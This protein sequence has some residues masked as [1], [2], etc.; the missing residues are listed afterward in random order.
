ASGT[1]LGSDGVRGLIA[2]HATAAPDTRLRALLSDLKR[3]KLVD[4]TTLLLIEEP[5]AHD[6]Q[7]LL[8][9]HMPARAENLREMRNALRKT[10]DHLGVEPALR[11]RLPPR[12]RERAGH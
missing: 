11:D 7:V 3:L 9:H 6:A 5:R 12:V 2:R 10:L 1:R 4:D 8:E